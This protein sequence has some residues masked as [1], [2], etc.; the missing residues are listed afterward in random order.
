MEKAIKK[1]Y[2]LVRWLLAAAIVCYLV[3]VASL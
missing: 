2:T 3:I 1:T